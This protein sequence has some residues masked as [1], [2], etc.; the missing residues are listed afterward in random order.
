M[1]RLL[2][3]GYRSLGVLWFLYIVLFFSGAITQ[4]IFRI[5][6]GSSILFGAVVLFTRQSK[7]FY[8]TLEYT[9]N[10]YVTQK[11]TR[12]GILALG[13][14]LC[15]SVI[16]GLILDYEALNGTLWDLA[17]YIAGVA[18]F[19]KT[20]KPE[21]H[22]AGDVLNYFNVHSSIS[23]YILKY[24]YKFKNSAYFLLIWQGLHLCLPAVFFSFAAR[25]FH[26]KST[27]SENSKNSMPD[28]TLALPTIRFVFACLGFI[29]WVSSPVFLGQR[30]WPYIFHIGGLTVL[31]A[32][33]YYYA[34]Q[35]YFFWA[36]A[37]L[38]LPLEKEDFGVISFAF[39]FV[40]LI[41][42][43]FWKK[44]QKYQSLVLGFLSAITIAFSIYY[45]T[46]YSGNITNSDAFS[47][48]FGAIASNP[49]DFIW[50]C[51]QE[52]QLVMRLLWR[53]EALYYWSFFMVATGLW[54][55]RRCLNWHTWKF[56]IPVAPVLFFNS[57]AAI[58]PMQ[59]FKD[60]YALP[61]AVGTVATLVFG[62]W[63][64]WIKHYK[65]SQAIVF[66]F[67]TAVL[68]MLWTHQS[69]PPQFKRSGSVVSTTHNRA[70]HYTGR[71]KTN[72]SKPKTFYLLRGTSMHQLD[73]LRS[74]PL[75]DRQP[76]RRRFE[77]T[78]KISSHETS[79]HNTYR[80]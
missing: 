36:I 33:Y 26:I 32:A 71:T 53:P 11:G 72:S 37:L 34:K 63:R 77:D 73:R 39:A 74:R 69:P 12:T 38:L 30:F 64:V 20:G 43:L 57:V 50:R 9:L 47:A 19:V 17:Q 3:F 23:I 40:G 4:H 80:K 27:D 78:H 62:T 13:I 21:Y 75:N 65:P 14:S 59:L 60:H 66:M 2:K 61:I 68:P 54:S 56:F 31:S 55:H 24:I 22:F 15:S 51:L 16:L 44:R 58:G 7:W 42:A 41:D 45:V 5:I 25:A 1:H 76:L 29:A 48:R 6:A 10:T 18:S 8:R 35:R 67:T 28:N 70:S 46:N 49:K 79:F 52:P